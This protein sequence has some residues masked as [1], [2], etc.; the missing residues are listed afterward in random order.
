MAGPACGAP[1]RPRWNMTACPLARSRNALLSEADRAK[2]L[3]ISQSL[4][5]RASRGLPLCGRAWRMAAAQWH[6]LVASVSAVHDGSLGGHVLPHT[7]SGSPS[8]QR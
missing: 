2:A 8:G 7:T 6:C 3:S 5:V 4:R 1:G